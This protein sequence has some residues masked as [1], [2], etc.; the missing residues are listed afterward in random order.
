MSPASRCLALVAL[1]FLGAC[2]EPG[3]TVQGT[4]P[5]PS[6]PCGRAVVVVHTD[7]QSTAVSV[8]GW[9]GAVLADPLATSAELGLSG[10]VVVPTSPSN[11]VVLMDRFPAAVLTRIDPETAAVRDQLSLATG[12]ASNPQDFV[13]LAPGPG[14]RPRALVTRFGVDLDPGSEPFDGGSDALVLGGEPLAIDSRVDLRPALGSESPPF[15]PR[16]NRA[17]SVGSRVF[18][19]LGGYAL[20]FLSGAEGRLVELDGHTGALVGV[21]VLEGLRGCHALAAS[22]SGARLAVGC[23]GGFGGTSEPNAAESAV[24]VFDVGE[25]LTERGRLR[26]SELGGKP[27][28]FS[29]QFLGESTL[30][31]GA[32][33]SLDALGPDAGAEGE[34]DELWAVELDAGSPKSSVRVITTSAFALGEVRC[35]AASEADVCG[36]FVADAARDPSLSLITR[37]TEGSWRLTGVAVG[38]G[39]GLPA[40]FLGEIGSPSPP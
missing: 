28:S 20:D 36:C 12:F 37:D 17:V 10:D 23:S 6:G 15:Y 21:T 14:A 16:A 5:L 3:P 24:M 1:A 38:L 18:V 2:T 29:L 8:V 34:S 26:P 22:P 40:R 31:A 35:P 4:G 7:Y 30:L 13:R 39:L 9:D 19:L 32:F 27:F 25:A 33:G 11:E